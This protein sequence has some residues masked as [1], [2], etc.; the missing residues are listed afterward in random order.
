M[1]TIQNVQSFGVLNAADKS[2]P[3]NNTSKED[4][5]L[6][7]S[8]C[9]KVLAPVLEET[10]YDYLDKNFGTHLMETKK[11]SEKEE[12]YYEVLIKEEENS[13]LSFE[14]G[15]NNVL[16]DCAVDCLN[17]YLDDKFGT[18]LVEK[19]R[20][21]KEEEV[22]L[23]EEAHEYQLQKEVESSKTDGF[24]TSLFSMLFSKI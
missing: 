24:L 9:N 7:D 22:K 14:E 20:I 12:A 18:N 15:I 4:D 23:L 13:N 11:Q 3:V 5:S 17:E 10:A 19:D 1:T 21:K 2:K 16:A 6:W 8:F